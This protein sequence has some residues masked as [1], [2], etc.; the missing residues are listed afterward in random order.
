MALCAHLVAVIHIDFDTRLGFQRIT[1]L[2]IMTRKTGQRF[3]PAAMIQLD[4]AM[5]HFSSLRNTDRFVI[6]TLA[7]FKTLYLVLAGIGPEK[8]T[9]ISCSHQNGIIRQCQDGLDAF[10]IIKRCIRILINLGDAA[11]FGIRSPPCEDDEQ[12]REYPQKALF[13]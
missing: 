13:I 2:F 11:L 3:F 10:F 5:G 8:S 4:I 12:D 9:L 1:F 6:M 7:A